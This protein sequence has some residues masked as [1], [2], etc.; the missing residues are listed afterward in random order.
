M[1]AMK[2]MNGETDPYVERLQFAVASGNTGD[3][4]QASDGQPGASVEPG[5]GME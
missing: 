3:P 2:V 1:V 5:T 4:D